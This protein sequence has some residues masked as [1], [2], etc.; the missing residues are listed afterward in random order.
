[1]THLTRGTV[2]AGIREVIAELGGEPDE[3]LHA[4]GI[5]PDA[6]TRFDRFVVYEQAAAVLG[7]VAQRWDC[8]DI[9][10][11][12]GSR[13]SVQIL[14][15]VGVIFRNAATVAD[16]L[17][18]VCRFIGNIAPTDTA[19]LIR[20]VDAG[21]FSYD[22]DAP[23]PL[24]RAQMVEK[25]L[26]V[27]IGAFRWMLG[28]A[29]TP[30]QVTFRHSRLSPPGRYVDVFGCP[31]DFDQ[32]RNAIHLPL[33]SLSQPVPDRDDIAFSLAEHY[34]SEH[35]PEAALADHVHALI[36]RLLI[37]GHATLVG[38]ADALTMHPRTLQRRLADEDTT[39]EEILD[40]IRRESTWEL[41]RTGMPIAQIAR[42]L[43]YSEQSS[44]ARAC[45]RWYGTSPR[46]L[47]TAAR[48]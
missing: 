37:I 1:M 40:T 15:P 45:H 2:L 14:G 27:A 32:E 34:L 43:G 38:V 5:D 42:E 47:R 8:P 10:L 31:V 11:R 39:F 44:F 17:D 18:G 6:T 48:N 9:G 7:D 26:A 33:R 4:H 30:L 20:Q 28:S 13:Q 22:T 23:H 25:S 3:L 46:Q 36:R 16:A 12:L 29:F 21:V 19:A 35:Q 24:D 41:C